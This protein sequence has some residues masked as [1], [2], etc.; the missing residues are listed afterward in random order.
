M[1]VTGSP[2][3]H[4]STFAMIQ[5][6]EP[7]TRRRNTSEHATCGASWQPHRTGGRSRHLSGEPPRNCLHPPDS[8]HRRTGACS[9][10][11]VCLRSRIC[12]AGE[13]QEGL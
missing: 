7:P 3:S 8:R 13:H 1:K 5:R 10:Q 6:P 12:R 4:P 11:P 9:L 2:S